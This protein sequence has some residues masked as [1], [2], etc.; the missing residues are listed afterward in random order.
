[1]SSDAQNLNQIAELVIQVRAADIDHGNMHDN[2]PLQLD[3][4]E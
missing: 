3:T 4:G 2:I 1:M